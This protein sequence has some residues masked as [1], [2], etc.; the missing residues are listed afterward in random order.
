MNVQMLIQHIKQRP[1]MFIGSLEM[2]SLHQFISGF[3]FSNIMNNQADYVDFAF[4][5][6]F[7]EW[8]RQQME[9]KK[10]IKYTEQRNY[11]YYLNQSFEKSEVLD[12]FFELCEEFFEII[13]QENKTVKGDK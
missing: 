11:V 10:N 13:G 7:H 9:K 12:A 1:E 2:E 6:R 8:I 3:L 4:K 5:N